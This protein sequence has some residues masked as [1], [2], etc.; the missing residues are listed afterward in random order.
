M[1]VALSVMVEEVLL[2]RANMPPESPLERTP[3]KVLVPEPEPSRVRVKVVPPLAFVLIGVLAVRVCELLLVQDWLPERMI[4]EIEDWRVS[5]PSR[6]LL[7]VRPP[8]PRVRVG[9][10]LPARVTV[11]L[12]SVRLSAT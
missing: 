8:E 6:V 12:L 1:L 11:P 7:S 10:P 2:V 5:G 9:E 3:E 4:L